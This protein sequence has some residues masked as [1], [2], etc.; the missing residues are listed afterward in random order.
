MKGFF[1]GL[2]LLVLPV[3]GLA[4]GEDYSRCTMGGYQTFPF[5]IG[6]KGDF[7]IRN[8]EAVKVISK[9]DAKT[10]IEMDDPA[11]K[12][13]TITHTTRYTL[14]KK[15]GRLHSLTTEMSAKDAK[16]GKKLGSQGTQSVFTTLYGYEG[17]KCQ[18]NQ[19]GSRSPLEKGKK[20]K[21][22]FD[23]K[24]CQ[25]IMPLVEQVGYDK[26]TECSGVFHKIQDALNETE[27][28]VAAEGNV[29]SANIFST[30]PT[31]KTKEGNN[32]FAAAGMCAISTHLFSKDGTGGGGMGIPFGAP[33]SFPEGNALPAN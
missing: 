25:Q 22:N 6:P 11:Y 4:E 19:M 10:V 31:A 15:E 9:D 26:F 5:D 13:K 24:F 7:E 14:E 1:L 28:R 20:L 12:G 29:F 21:I 18:V 3:L 32:I 23:R 30:K 2:G 33:I 27:D 8:K 16:S 17:K